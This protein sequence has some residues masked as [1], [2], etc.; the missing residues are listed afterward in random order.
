MSLKLKF[1]GKARPPHS[2][3]V[4]ARE[5][6][7]E[8][9][10]TINIMPSGV[11]AVVDVTEMLDEDFQDDAYYFKG[12]I[13]L[14]NEPSCE[15]LVKMLFSKDPDTYTQTLQDYKRE[16]K[17]YQDHLCGNNSFYGK[18][19]PRTYGCY[20]TKLIWNA[21]E[22]NI[23]VDCACAVFQYPGSGRN[24]VWSTGAGLTDFGVQV[25]ELLLDLHKSGIT[26]GLISL[27]DRSITCLDGKPFFVNFFRARKHICLDKP[28][29]FKRPID[30]AQIHLNTLRCKELGD[31]IEE[32]QNHVIPL[33]YHWYG[34]DVDYFT[35]DSLASI[36][37]HRR[38]PYFG[39]RVPVEKQWEYAVKVWKFLCANWSAYHEGEAPEVGDTS[40][41]AYKEK[42]GLNIIYE[43][44]QYD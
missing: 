5:I 23:P 8:Q 44:E 12:R 19:V 10:E 9:S 29:Q 22:R 40:L 39:E 42:F 28:E 14:P 15:V 43:D 24:L 1:S 16:A 20:E 7:L 31:F 25:V 18:G 32:L 4:A 13:S 2:Y 34:Y 27:Y 33:R 41:A 26:H 30:L 11:V 35:K 36:F 6:T 38:R 21:L 17:F 37:Q 3:D